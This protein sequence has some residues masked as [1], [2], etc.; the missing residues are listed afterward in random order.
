GRFRYF[1]EIPFSD[2]GDWF[3]AYKSYYNIEGRLI[4]FQKETNFFNNECTDE[5]AHEVS[6]KY[7]NSQFE[8]IDSVYTLTDSDKNP[9]KRSSCF[10]PYN[11]PFKI[12]RTVQIL[13][14]GLNINGY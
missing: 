6:L 3:I 11:Y 9:L 1:V 4:A 12:Y 10:F 14:K 13:K 5:V 8:L 7:Y 2:S